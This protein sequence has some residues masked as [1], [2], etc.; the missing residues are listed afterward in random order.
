MRLALGST[1]LGKRWLRPKCFGRFGAVGL[2]RPQSIPRECG[3]A[4]PGRRL[5]R[6]VANLT[7][8]GFQGGQ[9]GRLLVTYE[10]GDGPFARG[11]S[12]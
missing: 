10:F 3:Q 8:L 9:L 6:G 12:Y 11:L 5:V 4:S 7:P 1:R 2:P